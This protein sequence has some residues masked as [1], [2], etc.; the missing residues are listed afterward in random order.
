MNSILNGTATEI[1]GDESIEAR[2]VG[3]TA[4]AD[5]MDAIDE[6]FKDC[7]D[8]ILNL[9]TDE[10]DDIERDVMEWTGEIKKINDLL[11]KVYA[12]ETKRLEI[13]KKN[14]PEYLAYAKSEHLSGEAEHSKVGAH[15]N[16]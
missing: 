5:F 10:R 15:R 7:H 9:M 11:G 12:L 4:V 6:A 1:F 16:G 8:S 13:D 3:L 14:T 2:E